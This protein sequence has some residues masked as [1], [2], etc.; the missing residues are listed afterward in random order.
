MV[1]NLKDYEIRILKALLWEGVDNLRG[2]KDIGSLLEEKKK[3]L[4]KNMEVVHKKLEESEV[5]QDEG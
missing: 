4:M 2:T 3:L 1:V 5:I